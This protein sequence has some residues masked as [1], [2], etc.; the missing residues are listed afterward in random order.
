MLLSIPYIPLWESLHVPAL[1]AKV[2]MLP[3]KHQPKYTTGKIQTFQ[4]LVTRI[5]RNKINVF[6]YHLCMEK[7]IPSL[8]DFQ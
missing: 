1:N 7:T 3:L 5:D 2:I 8:N 6:L 4:R